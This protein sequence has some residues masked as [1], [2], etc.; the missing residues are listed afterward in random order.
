MQV[1]EKEKKLKPIKQ[2]AKPV[3]SLLG[4]AKQPTETHLHG[5][6]K[7]NLI[8]KSKGTVN[9]STS[10][11]QK[12]TKIN[13]LESVCTNLLEQG[14]VQSFIDLFYISHKCMPNVMKNRNY[15]GIKTRIPE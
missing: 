14:M 6:L 10:N 1:K 3:R 9:M 12:E 2:P 15:F 5:V 8:H 13:T 11:Q 7:D 4:V